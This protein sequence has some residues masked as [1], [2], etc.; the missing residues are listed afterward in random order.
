LTA[1]FVVVQFAEFAG[2]VKL[3][4]TFC[5]CVVAVF[6]ITFAVVG[7]AIVITSAYHSLGY[8]SLVKASAEEWLSVI[9]LMGPALLLISVIM[10]LMLGRT[11]GKR[12]KESQRLKDAAQREGAFELER[13]N[14]L[15]R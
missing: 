7:L 10:T 14:D 5:H 3:V 12:T 9:S 11:E 15:Y 1:C 4:R 8:G 13:M 6:L 2:G